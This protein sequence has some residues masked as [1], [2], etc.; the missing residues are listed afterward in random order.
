MMQTASQITS[1]GLAQ[2]QELP[3][4]TGE[5]AAPALVQV[6]ETPTVNQAV[7]RAIQWHPS[8]SEAVGKL[9]E[10]ASQ[11]DVAQAKYY[12]QV[13]AGMDNGYSNAYSE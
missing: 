1:T 13:S 7:Q 12:P 11:V 2:Q 5:S 3:S 9:L 10:Q 6:P 4:F 8:I